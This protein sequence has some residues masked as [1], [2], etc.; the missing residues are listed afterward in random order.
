M[1]LNEDR[2]LTAANVEV[3]RQCSLENS[4]HDEGTHL[5]ISESRD[6][7]TKESTSNLA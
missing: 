2:K 5:L 1:S 4:M 7:T 6:R 3:I